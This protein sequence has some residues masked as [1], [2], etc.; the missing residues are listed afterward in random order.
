MTKLCKHMTQARACLELDSP[1]IVWC[2]DRMCDQKRAAVPRH[3]ETLLRLPTRHQRQDYI[4]RVE[5]LDGF[6]AASLIREALCEAWM[7]RQGQGSTAGSP[8]STKEYPGSTEDKKI[9]QTG[10]NGFGVKP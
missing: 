1:G 3:V 8:K 7:A 2:C 4:A 6:E 9:A 10:F 5:S